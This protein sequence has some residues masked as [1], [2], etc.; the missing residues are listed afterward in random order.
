[1]NS[2]PHLE[3]ILDGK[4][5]KFMSFQSHINKVFQSSIGLWDIKTMVNKVFN[6]VQRRYGLS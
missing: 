4:L 1:M 3:D 2:L 6:Q 5:N